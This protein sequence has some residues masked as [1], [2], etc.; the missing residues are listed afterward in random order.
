MASLIQIGNGVAAA[1]FAIDKT[2]LRIGR[3]PDNDI[4]LD[5][6]LVSKH[7]AV[8]ELVRG[9]APG[10]ANAYYL[11]DLD[12]TNRT[13][14]DE[15][16]VHRHRLVHDETVRIGISTFKFYNEREQDLQETAKLHK[17]W[18]PGVYYTKS[19]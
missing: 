15:R 14:V 1:R 3:A 19:K 12:S 9:E 2:H 8:V 11:V 13:Y 10:S 5:N 4:R 17:S 18:I 16:P 7:H 6:P